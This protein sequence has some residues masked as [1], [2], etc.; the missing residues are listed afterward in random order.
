MEE[1]G[2]LQHIWYKLLDQTGVPINGASVWLYEYDNPTTQ[3]NVF[4]ENLDP[5]TQPLLTTSGGVLDFYV[6]D[7]FRSST[8]GYVWDKQYIISWSKDDKS[9]IIRGD[10]LFGEF[11]PVNLSGSST[12]RNKT[13]SNYQGWSIENHMN[14]EFGLENRCG[15]TSSSSISSSSSSESSSSSLSSSSSSSSSSSTPESISSSSSS[16]SFTPS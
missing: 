11:K 5:I 9:G 10:H 3:L 13:I 6:K 8:E 2:F 1:R 7:E 4:D 14:F 15:S 16:E 12:R